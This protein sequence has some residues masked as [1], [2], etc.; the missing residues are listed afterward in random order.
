MGNRYTSSCDA[1]QGLL[2]IHT[3][4]SGDSLIRSITG[5]PPT[6]VNDLSPGD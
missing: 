4:E 3:I 2:G 5:A 1:L 6:G